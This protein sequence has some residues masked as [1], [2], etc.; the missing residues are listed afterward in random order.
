M[1]VRSPFARRVRLALHEHHIEFSETPMDVFNPPG[2]FMRFNPLMRVPVVV[3]S[4]GLSVTD[5]S[6]IIQLLYEELHRSPLIPKSFEKKAVAANWSGVAVGVCEMMVQY[7]L[8][9]LRDD[10]HR[11]PGALTEYETNIKNSVREFSQF[12]GAREFIADTLSQADLDMGT[13]LGYLSVRHSWDWKVSYP[14]VAQYLSQIEKRPSF[15]KTK[16]PPA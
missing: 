5:S 6:S 8:E 9:G 2:E 4:D 1:S 7:F 14:N 13:A 16:P 11:S 10:K 3:F 12:L 15:E